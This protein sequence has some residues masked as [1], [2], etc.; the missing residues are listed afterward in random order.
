MINISR[1]NFEYFLNVIKVTNK[2]GLKMFTHRYSCDVYINTNAIVE[3]SNVLWA[4]NFV[5]YNCCI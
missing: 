5:I 1:H 3:E 4:S 2:R